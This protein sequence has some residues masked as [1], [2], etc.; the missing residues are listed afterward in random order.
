M[1]LGYCA[2]SGERLCTSLVKDAHMLYM[3]NELV[4]VPN[5]SKES[6]INEHVVYNVVNKVMYNTSVT[7]KCS[8]HPSHT[9]LLVSWP[10]GQEVSAVIQLL[11]ICQIPSSKIQPA[12]SG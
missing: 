2:V 10:V 7:G 11:E 5:F 4:P 8:F 6:L 1:G 9:A 3:H 12:S